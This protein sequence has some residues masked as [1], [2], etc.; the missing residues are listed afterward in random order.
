MN[1]PAANARQVPVVL[2]AA[3]A[4]ERYGSIKQLASINGEPMLL[5]VVHRLLGVGAPVIVVTGA[6]AAE[7]EAALAGLPVRIERHPGWAEGMGSSLAAGARRVIADFPD[8]TGVLICLADQPLLD[9]ELLRRMLARHGTAAGSILTTTQRGVDGPPALFPCDC[10]GTL[11]SWSGA[12]GARALLERE[13]HRVNRFPA[14][15]MVDV[16]TPA[17]LERVRETLGTYRAQAPGN[18]RRDA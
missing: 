12:H 10:F 3:G 16:D 5:R 18:E 2:L 14:S 13:A 1:A 7:V 15:G 9:I 11:A 17:D 8:A 4:G 6:H